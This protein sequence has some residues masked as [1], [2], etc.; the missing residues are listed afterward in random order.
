MWAHSTEEDE[1]QTGIS[2]VTTGKYLNFAGLVSS[3][4]HGN[5]EYTFFSGLF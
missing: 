2:C 1:A 3:C 4:E 5:H